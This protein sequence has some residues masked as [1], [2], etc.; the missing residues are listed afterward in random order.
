MAS[1]NPLDLEITIISA[2]H[3]KNVNWRNGDLK[4]YV[5]FYIDSDYRLATHSDDSGSTRPVW[6]ERFTL[7][8]SRPVSESILSLEIFHSKVSEAPKPLVGSLKFP[9]AHL[10]DSDESAESFVRNLELLRPSGRSQGKIRVKLAIKE[11]PLPPPSQEYQN[12]PPPPFPSPAR[13]YS[14]YSGYYSPQPPPPPPPRPMFGRASSFSFPSGSVPSAPV[15]YSTSNDQRQPPLPP[16]SMYGVPI[17]SG[18]SAPV[19]YAPYDQKL[20]KQFGGLSLEEEVNKKEKEKRA[21][22]EMAPREGYSYSDYRH[23]Y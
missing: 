18:P 9:L 20:P 19:D 12:T 15:D 3:L 23:D 6:N 17:G 5:V 8:I 7:P 4:P 1:P 11:R 21:E 10:L 13:D 14:Y 22:S 2:K 16:R